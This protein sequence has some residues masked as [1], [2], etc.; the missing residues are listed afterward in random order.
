MNLP[1]YSL[2]LKFFVPDV[3]LSALK[4]QTGKIIIILIFLCLKMS[5]FSNNCHEVFGLEKF[6][7]E[8]SMFFRIY[9]LL[10]YLLWIVWKWCKMI[11]NPSC[12]SQYHG[13]IS[14]WVAFWVLIVLLCWDSFNILNSC[15][16]FCK[17]SEKD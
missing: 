8:H 4:I 6:K 12:C 1:N 16:A 10:W 5:L 11:R 7:D 14:L 3:L 9:K 15:C 2:Y 17:V 13:C